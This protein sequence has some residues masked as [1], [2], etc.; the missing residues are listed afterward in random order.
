MENLKIVSQFIE[1][2]WNARNFENLDQFIHPDFKDNSL[3]PALT[4]D[5]EGMKKWVLGT[6]VS[7]EHKTI[8][9]DHV[10]EGDKIILKIRMEMKHIGIWRDIDPTGIQLNAAGYR[11]FKLQNGKIMEHSALIDGQAIENQLKEAQHGC[12]IVG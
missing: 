6:G 5:K 3:P 11:Y 7:F 12:K 10:S 2:I 1:R 9:E 8:I 4:A